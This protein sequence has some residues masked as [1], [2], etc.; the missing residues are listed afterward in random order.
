MVG[1][2]NLMAYGREEQ[3]SLLCL[4]V[5]RIQFTFIQFSFVIVHHLIDPQL[6]TIKDK[7]ATNNQH[8]YCVYLL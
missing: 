4:V 6:K 3:S 1:K 5:Y 7:N 8:K 2:N